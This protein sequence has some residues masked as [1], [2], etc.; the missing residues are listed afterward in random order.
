MFIPDKTNRSDKNLPQPLT[1]YFSNCPC[2]PKCLVFSL[3]FC[4]H[5]FQLLI[6]EISLLGTLKSS[7]DQLFSFYKHLSPDRNNFHYRKIAE[8]FTF[9]CLILLH[10]HYS[11]PLL[12]HINQEHGRPS[13]F[14]NQSSQ[15]TT[16]PSFSNEDP[17]HITFVFNYY[18]LCSLTKTTFVISSRLIFFEHAFCNSSLPA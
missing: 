17:S 15:F 12:Q 1:N 13:K 7:S 18:L 10:F 2:C 11:N 9:Y 3:Y 6:F 14:T 4:G 16:V 5:N 8:H